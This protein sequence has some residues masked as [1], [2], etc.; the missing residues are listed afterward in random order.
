MQNYDLKHPFEKRF[1]EK[2]TGDPGSAGIKNL[3]GWEC[4]SCHRVYAPN[5]EQCKICTPRENT[6]KPDVR[7]YDN[8]Y[9]SPDT[10]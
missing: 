6:E 5:V 2:G 3:Q 7:Y 10:R 8:G 4:P 9:T 1:D